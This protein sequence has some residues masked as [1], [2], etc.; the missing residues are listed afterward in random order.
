M[1]NSFWGKRTVYMEPSTQMQN[2]AS[3]TFLLMAVSSPSYIQVNIPHP[4]N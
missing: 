1:M 4:K 3:Y 2:C